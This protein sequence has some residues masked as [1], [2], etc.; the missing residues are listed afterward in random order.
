MQEYSYKAKNR[1]GKVIT[2]TMSAP[3]ENGVKN[4]LYNRGL[5]PIKVVRTAKSDS[6]EQIKT[7]FL[8]RDREGKIQIA[9]GSTLP[10]TKELALFT[11]QFSLMVENGIN[12]VSALKLLFRGQKKVHFANIIAAIGSSIEKGSSLYEAMQPFPAVFDQLYVAM[13]RA[14]EK[15]GKLDLI[16]R[17][18]VSYIEKSAR[19]KSQVKSAMTYPVL[20]VVVAITVITLLLAFVVPTFAKQ[21]AESGQQLPELTQMVV[22]FSDFLVNEWHYI[23]GVLVGAYLIFRYWL[24]TDS[25]RRTAD[26]FLLKAP[27]LGDV[28]K[29]IAIGRF[30]STMATMLSSG[31]SILDSLQI[32][33]NAS[34]NTTIEDFILTVKDQIEKG[35]SFAEPLSKSPLFP[36]MVTSMV[37]VGESTGKLDETLQKITAIYEDEVDTAIE[38]MTS[39]IEPIMIVVIG[40]I[41]GFIVLAMYLPIF[42]MANTAG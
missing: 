31:V 21:F 10:T 38:T 2:G 19:I 15:S 42:D 20:I 23:L 28:M 41:V 14:G 24:K 35:G 1:S 12:I 17:Q 13:I 18:L 33:A 29:K 32:C 30:C 26:A 4:S 39:M 6:S 36:T 5:S 22:D 37:E 16:L 7:G 40:G 25:G 3:S 9:L 27:I 8:Y 34:G 11:K